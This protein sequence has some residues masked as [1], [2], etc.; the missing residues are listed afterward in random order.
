[1]LV[2]ALLIISTV[3]LILAGVAVTAAIGAGLAV[4]GATADTQRQMKLLAES[5]RLQADVMGQ[6]A[7]AFETI[8]AARAGDRDEINKLVKHVNAIARAKANDNVGIAL[9][10]IP[11]ELLPQA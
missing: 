5:A 3:S 2:A 8:S 4:N 1:M 9:A 11:A 10:A 7:T 6:L